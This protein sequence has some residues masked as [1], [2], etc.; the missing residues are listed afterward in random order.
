MQRERWGIRGSSRLS[1]IISTKYIHHQGLTSIRLPLVIGHDYAGVV[2]EVGTAVTDFVPGD[3]VYGFSFKAGCAAEYMLLSSKFKYI[4]SKIPDE[5]SFDDAASLPIAAHTA[6]QAL[7]RADNEILGGLE[8]KTVLVTAG[9]GGV[10]TIALQLLKPVFGAEKVIT[11]V[12]TKK[13]TL[14]AELLGEGKVDQ[15]V[16]YT[17]QDVVTEIGKGTVDFFLDTANKA[18]SYVAV[19]KPE[20]GFL[21]SIVGKSGETMAKDWA[22]L[23]W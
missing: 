7:T 12:S 13:V 4:I 19:V 1:S 18:M 16:D 3:R 17:T 22:E 15:I 2:S 5:L 20:T 11:T 10:G 9:L 23:P 8:G 6:I 21:L 14:V